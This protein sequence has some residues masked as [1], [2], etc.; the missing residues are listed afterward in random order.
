[1]STK[2]SSITVDLNN[3]FPSP[4]AVPTTVP[5]SRL[6]VSKSINNSTTLTLTVDPIDHVGFTSAPTSP[7]ELPVLEVCSTPTSTPTSPVELPVLE[8][9][10]TP[11]CV[12]SA[13]AFKHYVD[14]DFSLTESQLRRSHL[15]DSVGEINEIIPGLFVASMK[16][17]GDIL[18]LRRHNITG[19][20]NCCADATPDYFRTCIPMWDW[21]FSDLRGVVAASTA[22]KD[23]GEV[24]APE[25]VQSDNNLL[26][27]ASTVEDRMISYLSLNMVDGRDDD[28]SWFVPHVFH[29]VHNHICNGSGGV[30][31]HCEKGVSR[32][33]SF[34]IAYL[35]WTQGS[36]FVLSYF[37]CPSKKIFF[38][39]CRHQMANRVFYC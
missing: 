10:S 15:D 27:D 14:T 12:P 20:V 16:V 33:C 25:A 7:V 26:V 37:L 38:C 13:N 5:D 3:I 36:S 31:I 28:L 30:L 6:I 35:M 19:V 21:D 24:R 2:R 23:S 34:A 4:D 18:L 1:M 32:S 8:V 22:S 9:C 17:A 39:Y 29:F 11:I